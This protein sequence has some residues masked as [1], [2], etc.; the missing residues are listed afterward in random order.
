MESH[1]EL[2]VLLAKQIKPIWEKRGYRVLYD[3]DPSYENAGKIISAK[4]K[5]YHRE[6]ELSQLDIAI[7]KQGTDQVA[8]LVEIEETTDKPKT[9]LGDIFGLLFGRYVFFKRDELHIDNLSS[10]IVVGINKNSHNYR[11]KYIQNRVNEVKASLSTQNARIGK[12]VVKTYINE[13]ELLAKLPL[14]L[15]EAF[16]GNL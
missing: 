7:V 15:D 16:M 12:I 4:R 10:L 1:G 13:T 8:A 2:T 11:N 5:Q 6:D 3:H 14:F 9:I